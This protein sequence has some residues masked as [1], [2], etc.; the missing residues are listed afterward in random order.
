MKIYSVYDPEF[1]SYG[2]VMEGY[3]TSALVQTLKEKTPLPAG[4]EYVPEQ[5]DL[6]ALPIT[7][8]ISDR[9]FGGMPIEMGYCNGH[10]TKLNCLEYHRDSE[11]N[12]GTGAFIL[13][14]AKR[15]QIGEDGLLDTAEV[16]AFRAPAGVLVEVYAETLHY[17]PCSPKNGE[18]FQVLIVL[19]K[20]TNTEKPSFTPGNREDTLLTARNKWLLAHPDSDEA[21]GGAVIGLK[22]VNLDIAGDIG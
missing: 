6:Q 5:P 14:V 4:V 11:I 15:G 2:Q 10:N 9:L 20:G 8:E 3:D 1:K 13:L 18:G 22:G 7:Q 12:M 16:K 17:A 19:P 21:K